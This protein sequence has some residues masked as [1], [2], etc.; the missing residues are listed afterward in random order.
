MTPTRLPSMRA[1]AASAFRAANSSASI[2][3]PVTV[4]WSR[5]VEVMPRGLNELMTSVA[6]PICT[7]SRA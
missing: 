2:S 3:L 6:T 1:W 5:T 4:D 7:I